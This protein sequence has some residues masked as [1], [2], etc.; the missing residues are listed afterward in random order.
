[1]GGAQFFD[2]RQA[3]INSSVE[4]SP[5]LPVLISI[6]FI[7]LCILIAK[8]KNAVRSVDISS[9]NTVKR[10]ELSISATGGQFPALQLP[11]KFNILPC[12]TEPSWSES[13]GYLYYLSG[14]K[15]L[16]MLVGSVRADV[17]ESKVTIGWKEVKFS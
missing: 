2:G 10:K 8:K 1:M 14:L 4:V 3:K 15:N 7:I 12:H 9:H 6:S 16:K 17:E 5:T 13:N 11:E